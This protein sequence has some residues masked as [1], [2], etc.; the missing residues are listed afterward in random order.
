MVNW[1]FREKTP[2]E[3]VRDPVH[4]EFFADDAIRDVCEALVREGIQNSLDARAEQSSTSVV[5]RIGVRAPKNSEAD[6]V[7]ERRRFLGGLEAHWSSDGN[8]LSRPPSA[9]EPLHWLVF[10]DFGTT[11]L[12]GNPAQDFPEDT[13]NPFFAF[14]RAEGYSE[15]QA[16]QRGRWG[17]GKFAFPRASRGRCFFGLTVRHDDGRAFLMGRC[18][19]KSH[20]VGERR[21]TPD[22]YFGVWTADKPVMPFDDDDLIKRFVSSFGLARGEDRAGL[23]VVVPF[24]DPAEVTTAALLSAIVRGYWLAL[25]AG[26]LIVRLVEQ[27]GEVFEVNAASLDAALDRLPAAEQAE[28]R[29]LV[30]LARWGLQLPAD[31]TITTVMP[32][33]VGSPKWG[34]L[35]LT[36]PVVDALKARTELGRWR[37]RVPVRVKRSRGGGE[38]ESWFEVLL[39]RTDDGRVAKPMFIRE[40]ILISDVRARV[41]AG[42][43]SIVLV[44]DAPL[45]TFLGDSENPAHTRWV[46]EGTHFKGKY[47][48]GAEWIS[49]VTS[50]VDELV[51]AMHSGDDAADPTVLADVLSVMLPEAPEPTKRRKASEKQPKQSGEP[52]LDLPVRRARY[53]LAPADKGFAIIGA[54]NGLKSGTEISVQAAYDVRKGNPFKQWQSFDFEFMKAPIRVT[55]Q[56][57]IDV[58]EAAE[59]RVRLRVQEAEFRFVVSGFDTYRD[60]KVDVRVQEENGE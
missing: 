29:P 9:D 39:E 38:Q 46:R 54:P 40:G 31:E 28:L 34:P 24:V 2:Q 26:H 21:F 20:R 59:N 3:S 44:Q 8:G 22:G 47:E 19:L 51:H 17:L 43:R 56:R 27:D 1:R 50:S 48:R 53:R 12:T 36:E 33:T 60:L 5:V 58:V 32:P 16:T 18:T 15:K 23:S 13:P 7:A 42:W 35:V 45:A 55:E 41:P 57:G 52:A 49:F 25:L 14:F 11:G 10:E 6:L 30:A 4:E 37:V